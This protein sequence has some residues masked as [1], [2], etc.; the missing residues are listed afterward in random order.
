MIN[1][2]K[3]PQVQ[4][5]DTKARPVSQAQLAK[6][7]KLN[8]AALKRIERE[9]KTGIYDEFHKLHVT[10][11][12][13]HHHVLKPIWDAKKRGD[14]PSSGVKLLHFDS[15]PDMA[16]FGSNVDPDAKK[17]VAAA[18]KITPQIYHD[19]F[20]QTEVMRLSDISDWVFTPVLQ[21]MV[22]EVI[23]MSGWWCTQLDKNATHE[24]Y[25]GIDREDGKMK[26]AIKDDRLKLSM[27][28]YWSTG[29]FAVKLEKLDYVRPFKMH[30]VHFNKKCKL[31]PEWMAKIEDICK[32]QPWILDIDEDYL[33][34]QNPFT[35]EFEA[36]FGES[37][38]DDFIEVTEEIYDEECE[39]KVNKMAES[40]AFFKGEKAYMKDPLVEQCVETL[41]NNNKHMTRRRARHVI[42][43]IRPLLSKLEQN[44]NVKKIE[45]VKIYIETRAKSNK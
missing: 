6:R 15:H 36:M 35:V 37:M 7:K 40:D 12:D 39:E 29:G 20:D 21:G 10:V 5:K 38:W 13:K 18:L 41:T 4:K 43:K 33:S 28:D 3:F 24:M 1:L 17:D 42:Q 11:V 19:N 34:T 27:M 9:G 26:V 31:E 8:A 16:V 30:V 22:D 32:G 14:L 44:S 45:N 2:Q 23:W 25:V